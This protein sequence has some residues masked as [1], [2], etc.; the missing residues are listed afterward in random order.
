MILTLG[1][2][3]MDLL[4]SCFGHSSNVHSVLHYVPFEI[5]SHCH[6]LAFFLMKDCCQILRPVS[7]NSTSD[8]EC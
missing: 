3:L 2:L 6:P 8:L 7:V 5:L 1:E 4:S